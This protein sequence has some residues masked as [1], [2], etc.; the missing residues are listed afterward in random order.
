MRTALA[1]ALA[2]LL[3]AM[4]A[5]A[6]DFGRPGIGTSG[7]EFLLLD[8]S[9]RGIAMGS[10]MT[11]VTDDSS[12]LYWN[13]AGLAKVPRMS[14]TF[15]HAQYVADITYEA[16]S[17]AQR[18]NDASVFGAGFRYLDGGSIPQTDLQGSAVGTFHPRSYV[19]EVGWGQSIYDLSDSDMDVA[20]GVTGKAIRSD[21]GLATANGYAVDVGIQT[22]IFTSALAYDAAFAVQ[23]IG[24][25]QKFDQVRDTLPLRIRLGGSV[26][27]VHA[28]TLSLEGVAP[29]NDAPYAA[30][31]VEYALEVERGI[32]GFARAGVNTLTYE[33]LGVSSM[34]SFGVGMKINDL[35]FDYAFVPMGVL[36]AATH[37]ITISINLPAKIS[38]R[39]RER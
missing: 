2:L 22:R 17:Y 1:A 8:T 39:Y 5:A 19:G 37:R 9:A 33:S 14:A 23:N 3:A 6:T 27:P 16:L 4:P 38:R 12:S 35:S 10:A 15:M 20:M 29:I 24:T 25:G 31:G 7:S 18:V 26:K 11:A 34:L 30:S 13:P 36:G 32:T 21:L 28:L